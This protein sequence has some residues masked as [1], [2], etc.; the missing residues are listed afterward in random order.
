MVR[1]AARTPRRA[2]ATSTA[3]D[4]MRRY[5][6]SLPPTTV[7]IPPGPVATRWRRA[8][9]ALAEPP[10]STTGRSPAQRPS[11][12]PGPRGAAV[13]PAPPNARRMMERI[14]FLPAYPEMGEA[15]RR[16]LAEVVRGQG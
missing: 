14:V 5:V 2:H 8:S 4:A 12:S 9:S 10:P 16:R 15:E 3:S 1:L 13:E 6:V 7:T 11:T